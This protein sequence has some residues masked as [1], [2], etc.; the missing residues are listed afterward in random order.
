MK[1]VFK[2]TYIERT[3]NLLTLF[4]NDKKSLPLNGWIHNCYICKLPTMK[5][6]YLTSNKRVFL[7]K[8]CKLDNY[9]RVLLLNLF[10]NYNK[11]L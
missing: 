3:F 11:T 8:T 10:Y 2:N 5:T 7:C 1:K 9:K 6:Y 4:Y